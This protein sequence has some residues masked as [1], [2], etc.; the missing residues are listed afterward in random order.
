MPLPTFVREAI[1]WLYAVILAH[2]YVVL[3]AVVA[4]EEA[5]LPL[6]APSDVVIAFYGYRARDEPSALAQVVLV[7]ALASTAGTLLP[8]F[9]TRR[10]GATLTR[11]LAR[12]VDVD[13]AV[14]D[15]WTGRIQR[16]GFT[17]VFVGRLIPGARVAMSLVAGTAGV[18]LREFSPAVFAAA[19]IYWSIWV[20]VGVIFGPAVREI[21]GPAYIRLFL[22][23]LPL[24]VVT[25]FIVRYVRARR[26][27][28]SPLR[29]G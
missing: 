29:R 6:P 1:G 23:G 17:A 21:I 7:C 22:I 15:R 16:R 24:A 28:A 4:I 20:A 8:Y 18:P 26:R 11:R 2:Q 27:A 5:G 19:S 14:I 9:L 3:F 10:F 13:D 25:F 12:L